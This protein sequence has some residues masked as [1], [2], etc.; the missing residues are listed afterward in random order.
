MNIK[1]KRR[2]GRFS[3]EYY[4]GHLGPNLRLSYSEMDG[5]NQ[6][7]SVDFIRRG[8]KDKPMGIHTENVFEVDS[9]FGGADIARESVV[10]LAK[11]L[12]HGIKPVLTSWESKHLKW[13]NRSIAQ[14]EVASYKLHDVFVRGAYYSKKY[15]MY[16]EVRYVTNAIPKTGKL[17]DEVIGVPQVVFEDIF[18][19]GIYSGVVSNFKALGFELIGVE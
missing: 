17:I 6:P 10:Y 11:C 18:S 5:E 14:K 1:F 9:F 7:Y 8:V 15:D 16:V 13:G 19:G 3:D 2:S 12:Y 4:T